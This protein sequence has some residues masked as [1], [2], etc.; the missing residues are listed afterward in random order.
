MKIDGLFIMTMLVHINYGSV[1]AQYCSQP[2]KPSYFLDL[3]KSDF[4]LKA[5]SKAS[6]T[7][8]SW[9]SLKL[10]TPNNHQSMTNV[11]RVL[12]SRNSKPG[13]INEADVSIPE[14]GRDFFEWFNA[15]VRRPGTFFVKLNSKFPSQK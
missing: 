9:A 4:S 14:R 10:S 15:F 7:E 13:K 12:Y 5:W 2:G 11:R 6:Y 1:F 3:S 8:I